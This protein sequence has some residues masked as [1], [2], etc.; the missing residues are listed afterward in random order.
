MIDWQMSAHYVQVLEKNT[1]LEEDNS[2]LMREKSELSER[3][4]AMEREV[5]GCLHMCVLVGVWVCVGAWMH[6][7][8]G[9]TSC[10]C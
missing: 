2:R 4:S 1:S 7:C 10:V 5:C 9:V 6:V 8:V 3:L